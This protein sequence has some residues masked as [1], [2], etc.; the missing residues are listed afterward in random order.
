MAASRA[1][2]ER[3]C[4]QSFYSVKVWPSPFQAEDCVSE[5]LDSEKTVCQGG[6]TEGWMST[7]VAGGDGVVP[8]GLYPSRNFKETP[9]TYPL[10]NCRNVGAASWRKGS[11]FKTISG[12]RL[13][14][15]EGYNAKNGNKVDAP[16]LG[17]PR[18]A[19][20][21][22]MQDELSSHGPVVLSVAKVSDIKSDK[23][24]RH[25]VVLHGWETRGD[26]F[27]WRAR[28]S[29]GKGDSTE[30]LYGRFERW[31][32]QD[33]TDVDHRGNF[34][35]LEKDFSSPILKEDNLRYRVVSYNRIIPDVDSYLD[36]VTFDVMCLPPV[37]MTRAEA[38]AAGND[39]QKSKTNNKHQRGAISG[40]FERIKASAM[41]RRCFIRAE[42][43]PHPGL[44]VRMFVELVDEGQRK[45]TKY[46]G[47]LVL[48][49]TSS[50]HILEGSVY[51]SEGKGSTAS[52][53]VLT[54]QLFG[55]SP[56]S[57]YSQEPVATREMFATADVFKKSLFTSAAQACDEAAHPTS[58][59]CSGGADRECVKALGRSVD[60]ES[61]QGRKRCDE[62]VEQSSMAAF[63][64]GSSGK[65]KY[66]WSD[67]DRRFVLETFHAENGGCVRVLGGDVKHESDSRTGR[68]MRLCGADMPTL[69]DTAECAGFDLK[70][71]KSGKTSRVCI[72]DKG[73]QPEA[74]QRAASQTARHKV[75]LAV[76]WAKLKYSK[77][78]AP[79]AP[80]QCPGD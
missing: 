38:K 57:G 20:R 10:K 42:V 6:H 78:G 25:A 79:G 2:A 21:K 13:E 69:V 71:V 47:K 50:E 12:S 51:L 33:E 24:L 41:Y 4:Q 54:F 73:K 52:G 58:G 18:A 65:K 56:D 68:C 32:T 66:S 9:K 70:D 43:P 3:M 35:I 34:L 44:N 39:P 62:A 63:F 22:G 80:P 67:S 36:K 37:T 46:A 14:Q 17:Q 75:C 19:F 29:W 76:R 23:H 16:Q 40:R 49:Q 11:W 30:S 5:K 28:N 27:Y 1:Y 64:S 59:M 15:A 8:I 77:G 61:F 60:R 55:Y 72:N 26:D 7:H 74:S 31:G 53:D 48:E 45:E